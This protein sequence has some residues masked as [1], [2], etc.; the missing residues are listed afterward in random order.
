MKTKVNQTTT[1]VLMRHV[2]H[3]LAP[4]TEVRRVSAS[5]EG[6]GFYVDSR[7]GENDSDIVFLSCT[8]TYP[9]AGEVEGGWNILAR[10][11]N[12]QFVGE[13]TAQGESLSADW[14]AAWLS[15]MTNCTGHNYWLRFVEVEEVLA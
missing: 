15:V 7:A 2:R 4:N 6:I 1:N 11:D 14:Y 12:G 9:E 13:W 5:S 8:P 10:L 3:I